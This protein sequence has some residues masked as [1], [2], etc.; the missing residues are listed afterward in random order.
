MYADEDYLSLSRAMGS[1]Q[2][3]YPG[4]CFAI[5]RGFSGPR[6]EAYRP[7]ADSGLYAVITDDPAEIRRELNQ[8]GGI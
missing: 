1:L 7:H 3:E 8:P 2:V 6:V 4:W 5:R